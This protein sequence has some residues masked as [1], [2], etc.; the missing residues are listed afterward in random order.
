MKHFIFLFS[1]I[2]GVTAFSAA[3]QKDDSS[4]FNVLIHEIA[5][6][7]EKVSEQTKKKFQKAFYKSCTDGAK[8]KEKEI[9]KNSKIEYN[10]QEKESI[11]KTIEGHCQCISTDK[12]LANAFI[13]LA[14][15]TKKDGET[16]K[17]HEDELMTALKSAQT[18]CLKPNTVTPPKQ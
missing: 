8:Q 6:S 11:W 3:E 13:A 10:K 9:Y 7:K 1:V 18:K 14:K 15:A 5:T 12:G 16:E 4:I 17:K 2:Y